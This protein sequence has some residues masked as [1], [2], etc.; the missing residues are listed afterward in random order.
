[1]SRAEEVEQCRARRADVQR[2]RRARRETYSYPWLKTYG[3][4]SESS[5]PLQIGFSL[6]SGCAPGRA[7]ARATRA[8]GGRPS[9]ARYARAPAD[10]PSA[11]PRAH[12]REARVPHDQHETPYLDATLRYRR[13]GL[14]AVPHPRA[15]DRQGRARRA[16]RA[17]RRRVPA[18][19]CRDGRRRGGHAGVHAPHPPRGGLRRRGLGR[20]P[21][22]VP[23]QWVHERHPRAGAHALRPRRRGDHPAQ[24]PQVAAR[25]PH[26][27]RGDARLPGAGGRRAVGHPAHRERR[28]RAAG[29]RRAPGGQGGSSSPHRRTTASAATLPKWPRPHTPRGCPS[30][31]TRRGGRTCASA[32]NCPW[33]R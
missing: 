24:R 25:R 14:H 16:P 1:M 30:S 18:G 27:L 7:G 5:I 12:H 6:S 21:L 8:L 33:T 13:G 26:L 32:P 22:L 23:R 19:R 10:P 28:G 9:R 20:R 29:S 31:P 2:A 11:R 15:Q 3:Y 4:S 17:S